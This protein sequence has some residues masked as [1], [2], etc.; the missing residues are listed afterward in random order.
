MGHSSGALSVDGVLY[1]W[2]SNSQSKL[3]HTGASS[4]LSPTSPRLDSEQGEEEERDE[5]FD[6]RTQKTT[7]AKPP[8][9]RRAVYKPR[10]VSAFDGQ[11]VARFVL[12]HC[13]AY[14]FT[15]AQV[16]SGPTKSVFTLHSSLGRTRISLYAHLCTWTSVHHVCQTI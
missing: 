6:S 5:A 9:P 13:N 8:L 11:Y 4:S 15:P 7:N 10:R 16:H 3:F 12:A 2:G 14:A 1:T